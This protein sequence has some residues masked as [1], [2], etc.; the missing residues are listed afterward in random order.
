MPRIL[1]IEDDDANRLL[2]RKLLERFPDY[3]ID[4]SRLERYATEFVQGYS[5]MPTRWR[6]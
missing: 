6:P 5:S 1:Y 2:V 4:T 3:E